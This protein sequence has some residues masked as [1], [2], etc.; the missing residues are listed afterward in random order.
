MD[1]RIAVSGAIEDL[2][3]SGITYEKYYDTI[4]N[5]LEVEK[6]VVTERL[7]IDPTQPMQKQEAD[8]KKMCSTNEKHVSSKKCNG[9]MNVQKIS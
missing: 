4:L 7:P 9:F 5:L 3:N 6:Q 2:E 8:I 1:K